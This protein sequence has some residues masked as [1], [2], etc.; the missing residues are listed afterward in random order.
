MSDRIP[1]IV[2][3]DSGTADDARKALEEGDRF[4]VNDLHVAPG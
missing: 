3:V 4:D 2:N 1:A